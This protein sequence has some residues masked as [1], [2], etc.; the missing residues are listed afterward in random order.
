MA[1]ARHAN[2]A[3]MRRRDETAVLDYLPRMTPR[4]YSAMMAWVM[5][6]YLLLFAVPP[7]TPPEAM[8]RYRECARRAFN[9]RVRRAAGH[10]FSSSS[11]ALALTCSPVRPAP[12]ARAQGT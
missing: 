1:D 5:C 7:A 11:C 6:I 3:Q 4:T 2:G 8:H 9:G 10:G 12:R